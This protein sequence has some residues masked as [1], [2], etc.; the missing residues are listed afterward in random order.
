MPFTV[1]Q[2]AF[3][4]FFPR[5]Q[6][7]SYWKS[8]YLGELADDAID[9]MAK[10]AEDRSAGVSPFELVYFDIFPMGGAVS[11]VDPAATAFGE[12]SAP[13]LVA[14]DAN[15]T[16]PADT[17]EGIGW[18]RDGWGELDDLAGTG[19]TY[20]NF[21]GGENGGAEAAVG[22]ALTSNLRRLGEVK[23]AYDPDNFFRRNNNIVPAS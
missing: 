4:G 7:Q 19:S 2:S 14:V 5:G 21:G 6:I 16:D 11:R 9:L 13:W 8:L 3:D 1:V 17:Q 20:L 12:R 10:R 22:E 18:V 23:R 15:W